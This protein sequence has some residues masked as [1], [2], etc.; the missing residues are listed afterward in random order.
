MLQAGNLR[1]QVTIQQRGSTQDSFGQP[2]APWA[3]LATV[4]ADVR[5]VSGLEMARSDAPINV[6]RAS[7]RIRFR[8]DV[9]AGMRVVDERGTVYDIQAVLPDPTGRVSLDLLCEQGATNG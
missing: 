1:H 5:Y 8:D 6:A 3:D 2:T 7:I 9:T 4:W